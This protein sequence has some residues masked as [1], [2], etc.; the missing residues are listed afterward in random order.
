MLVCKYCKN[1]VIVLF[2]KCVS[3]RGTTSVTIGESTIAVTCEKRLACDV[4]FDLHPLKFLPKSC[5]GL[6]WVG[7]GE[8]HF[9]IQTT[10]TAS[11]EVPPIVLDGPC[12][13]SSIVAALKVYETPNFSCSCRSCGQQIIA[14]CTYV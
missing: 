7:D 14:R 8:L 2:R 13:S 6:Q 12:T 11:G 3:T 4:T 5:R 10:T 1:K 9:R